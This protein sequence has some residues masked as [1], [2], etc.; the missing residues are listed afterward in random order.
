MS[1]AVT[2]SPAPLRAV[3]ALR[4]G[5]AR[6]ASVMAHVAGWTYIACALFITFDIVA[7]AFLGFSSQATVEVTG[8]ML[9]GGIAWALAHTLIRRA[10]IR[11]DVFANRLPVRLRAPLHVVSLLLLTALGVLIAWS[12]WELVDES[13]LFNAHDNSALRIELV[14]PQGIWAFGIS[15]FVVCCG[16]LLLEAVLALADGQGAALDGLLGSRTLEDETEEALEAVAM[17]HEGDRR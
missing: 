15:A 6:V 10:H 8:Y 4:R 3:R 17:A 1:G 2:P 13:V 7:R 9:A 11:V 14:W 12:A 16:V 5:V